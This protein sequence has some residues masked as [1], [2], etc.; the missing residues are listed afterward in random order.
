MANDTSV[1]S[2]LIAFVDNFSEDDLHSLRNEITA[3]QRRLNGLKKMEAMLSNVLN[4]EP[5]PKPGPKPKK[6]K[7]DYKI[8]LE[9]PEEPEEKESTNSDSKIPDLVG[10]RASVGRLLACGPLKSREIIVRLKFAP[11]WLA[12]IMAC[13]FFHKSEQGWHLTPAGRQAFC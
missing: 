8:D 2:K 3:T 9:E 5:L 1:G 4:A 11:V 12:E 7:E 6:V 13:P 10:K